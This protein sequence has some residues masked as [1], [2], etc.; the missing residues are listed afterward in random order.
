VAATPEVARRPGSGT[1][2]GGGRLEAAAGHPLELRQR[3]DPL[4]VGHGE[5]GRQAA[6]LA[7]TCMVSGEE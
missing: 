5:V 1:S 7:A 3:L 6:H 2:R 4:G